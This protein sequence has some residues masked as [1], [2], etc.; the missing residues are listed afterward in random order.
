M[1]V[2]E[3]TT[4][5]ELLTL[6]KTPGRVV[7]WRLGGSLLVKGQRTKYTNIV[8]HAT[9]HLYGERYYGDTYL[10]IK[11]DP[12]VYRH[13]VKYK[14]DVQFELTKAQQSPDGIV[15]TEVKRYVQLFNAY[16]TDPVDPAIMAT[17]GNDE[18]KKG[19]V[20]QA[21]N[22]VE[23]TFQLIEP[24]VADL[25]LEEVGGIFR[26][27]TIEKLLR[28]LL[29]YKLGPDE[30]PETLKDEKYTGIRGVDIMPPDNARVYDHIVIPNG[31]R[32]YELPKQLQE[33]YG[34]Y[35]SGL[36]WHIVRGWC[37]FYP[38]L[39]YTLFTQ[40]EKTLTILNVPVTEIPVM[41]R[42]FLHRSGQLYVFSTGDTAFFDRTEH[43]QLNK[44]TGLRMSRASDLLDKFVVTSQN[45]TT[46]NKA[47]KVAGFI[48]EERPDKKV[49]VRHTPVHFTDNPFKHTT[50]LSESMGT[51]V[52]V[53]WDRSA[54]ELL[55]PG[56][57]VKFLFKGEERIES[58]IG[59]LIGAE[60]ITATKTG[61][62]TD[63]NF[64]S[65][66]RLI[67]NLIRR[68]LSEGE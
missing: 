15:N 21:S 34:V 59:T 1:S 57:Q 55:Y 52:V 63:V 62:L 33:D 22:Q 20:V 67:I 27:V 35:A 38:L 25:R 10:T 7:H 47:E 41:E 45:K 2:R 11:V 3:S 13:I 12:V 64:I 53:E 8:K 19:T 37:F 30:N 58:L 65:R 29:S 6:M 14:N 44:G 49:N 66:T 68:D 48:L 61:A 46:F 24:V 18:D 39:N 51:P 42:T 5:K 36:G 54:P 60:S 28:T 40:R 16:L 23:I 26:N 9:K 50:P 56:M 4:Y 31:T 17:L 43:V 32:L